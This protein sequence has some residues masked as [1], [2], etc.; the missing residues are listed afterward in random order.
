MIAS[1][2][3]R[4]ITFA[5]NIKVGVIVTSRSTYY[6]KYWLTLGGN[7]PVDDYEDCDILVTDGSLKESDLKTSPNN[8]VNIRLWDYQVGFKGTGIHACAV[9]GAASSI[10]HS[11]GPGVALPND[12]PE[13]WCGA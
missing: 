7:P 11:D 12:I 13:K 3:K 10:G 4:N 8:K 6:A 9:S 2:K 5:S 1:K